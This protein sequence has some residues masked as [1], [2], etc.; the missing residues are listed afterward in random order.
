M[1]TIPIDELTGILSSLVQAGEEFD[2]CWKSLMEPFEVL[3]DRQTHLMPP[4]DFL[5]RF[6]KAGGLLKETLA[7]AIDCRSR[8]RQ[9]A[10]S[11][12]GELLVELDRM[13]AE[14]LDNG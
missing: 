8:L 7:Q 1:A 3:K 12:P 14:Q 2:H 6:S 9:L 13:L 5:D 4:Q 11:V 10:N